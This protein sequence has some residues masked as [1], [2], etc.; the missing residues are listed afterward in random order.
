MSNWQESYLTLAKDF[1]EL[2]KENKELQ[3]EAARLRTRLTAAHIGHE[4]KVT[5]LEKYIQE[6][7]DTLGLRNRSNPDLTISQ[8]GKS[9][10]DRWK[11]CDE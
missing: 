1:R 8:E 9:I 6:L 5:K 10:F 4:H 3:A 7:E 11:E 2:E